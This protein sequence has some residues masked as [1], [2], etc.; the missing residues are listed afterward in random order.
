[1]VKM[2]SRELASQDTRTRGLD[3]NSGRR[4]WCKA[5]LQEPWKTGAIG[6][7]PREQP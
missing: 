7:H 6:Q 1:M 3:V 5:S 2:R 4:V